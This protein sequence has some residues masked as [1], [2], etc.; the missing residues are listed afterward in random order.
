MKIIIPM[1]GLGLRFLKEGFSLPKPLIEI[2]GLPIISHV[3]KLFP[4]KSEFIFICNEDHLLK[5]NLENIL[6]NYAQNSRIISI[7]PHKLGPVYSS[8][9]AFP[10]IN[11]DEEI[12]VN[13]CDFCCFWD[14]N[15]FIEL[16]KRSKL[17]GCLPSY[18]KFHPHSL[19][20]NDYAF[21][22]EENGIVKQIKEKESFTS[23]KI[24]EYAS[25]GTYYFAKGSYVKKFF[26][27]LL[28]SN[29][30]IN[31]EYYC[32]LAYNLLIKDKKK[33]GIFELEHF[34]QWGTPEDF[35]EYK[36]WSDTFHYLNDQKLIKKEDTILEGITLIAAAG[37]GKRFKDAGFKT[38]K[39]LI[40]VYEKSMILQAVKSLPKSKNY[41]FAC[42]KS[43]MESDKF[44]TS[45]YKRFSNSVVIKFDKRTLGQAET[46][47]IASRDINQNERLTISSCDHGVLYNQ[48][49][50]LH[51][52]N[53]EKID[54]IVWTT[55]NYPYSLIN[56]A[57]YGW[58]T[59]KNEKVDDIFIKRRPKDIK[60][61]YLI[62]GTFTFRKASIF[63][64]LAKSLFK[65]DCKVN[66]EF[67]VDSC[68]EDA[69]KLGYRCEVFNV[70]KFLCWGSPD[71]LS[72]FN[73]WQK[74]FNKW[75]GHPYRI[76]NDI[77]NNKF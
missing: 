32:S 35:V 19:K 73:Y 24:N 7:K 44:K 62:I 23:S 55:K 31:G 46:C 12:I 48:E 16:I 33:V 60:N 63:I 34:M 29:Q 21:I 3:I 45:F 40:N 51:I 10:F 25:S 18:R 64:E 13:Y 11:D 68:I 49:K 52:I 67:Y 17:D 5:F 1:A 4:P 54:L 37:E 30:S 70:D 75:E 20:G 56:P 14:F 57:F 66:G 65:R 74:C 50:L 36:F 39:P 69:I 42:H 47:L 6:K 77:L 9:F 28:S 15:K 2:E 76:E 61:S 43:I 27:K 22:L 8:K 59:L 41:I 72:T 53:N 71:E 58:L 26:T 38:E